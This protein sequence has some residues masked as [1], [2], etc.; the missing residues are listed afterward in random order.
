MLK[1]IVVTIMMVS[2]KRPVMIGVVFMHDLCDFTN[3]VIGQCV[4]RLSKPSV[5]RNTATEQHRGSCERLQ[6]QRHQQEHSSEFEKT[7]PHGKSIPQ[8]PSAPIPHPLHR[9][10]TAVGKWT[11]HLHL[12]DFAW[13]A[14]LIPQP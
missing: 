13:M 5:M 6:R 14:Q 10:R 7:V 8:W 4:Q 2:T 1:L 12:T 3:V 11:G 9:L